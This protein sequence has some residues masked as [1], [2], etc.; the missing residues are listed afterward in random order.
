MIRSYLEV[1]VITSYLCVKNTLA[2]KKI[3]A[4]IVDSLQSPEKI[5]DS[6]DAMEL[7]EA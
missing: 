7:T 6:S 4:H 3:K 2:L 1:L 5:G